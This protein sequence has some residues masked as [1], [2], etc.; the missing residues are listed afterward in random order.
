LEKDLHSPSEAMTTLQSLQA[1]TENV[2]QE[3]HEVALELRPTALDDLGLVRA[4][5][6]FLEEWVSRSQLEIEFEH[7]GLGTERLPAHLETTLYRVICEAVHNVIKHAKAKRV[8]IILDRKAGRVVGTVEDNGIGFDVD[9]LP[10]SAS[11]KR[12][13][14]VGMKER[15]ALL[16]G[17]LTVE[18]EPDRG[19]TILVRL[20]LPKP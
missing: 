12:L 9:A 10:L 17:E 11:S 20:P 16:N 4:L 8:S 18:S 5:S 6:A 3:I 1:I 2:G 7:A 19:T 14:M 15:V 13:G